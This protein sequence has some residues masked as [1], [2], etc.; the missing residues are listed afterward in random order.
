MT[1]RTDPVFSP[2]ALVPGARPSHVAAYL[3]CYPYDHW[4]MLSHQVALRG[5]ATRLQLPEP[6][7]YFDNGCSWRGERPAWE[8]LRHAVRTGRYD[9]LL[10]PGPW[11][12]ALD[13]EHATSEIRRL[14][15]TGCQVVELPSTRRG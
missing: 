12:V 6:T 13:G 3:R 2:P 7:V 15:G 4:E 11:V 10:I 1:E 8:R 14:A 5:L 9:V